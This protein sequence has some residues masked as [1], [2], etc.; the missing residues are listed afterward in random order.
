MD[1]MLQIVSD[2]AEEITEPVTDNAETVPENENTENCDAADDVSEGKAHT[3]FLEA[4][5]CCLEK[6]V[7]SEFANDV[8]SLAAGYGEDINS[9]IDKVLEKYPF[10][11]KN[12]TARHPEVTTGV[13]I[14]CGGSSVCGGVEAAFRRAN[15]DVHF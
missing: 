7:D 4:K 6:G 14:S 1:E 2:T 3:A 5:V 12:I 11:K 13:H 8:I 9:A 10:F 15:P